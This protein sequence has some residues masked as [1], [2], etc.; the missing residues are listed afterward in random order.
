MLHR[1]VFSQRFRIFVVIIITAW[2][3]SVNEVYLLAFVVEESIDISLEFNMKETL[4]L[5]S[6][7]LSHIFTLV[8]ENEKVGVQRNSFIM[9]IQLKVILFL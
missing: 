1:H 8:I 6:Q 4:S 2:R 7:L 9:F 3:Y 5:H